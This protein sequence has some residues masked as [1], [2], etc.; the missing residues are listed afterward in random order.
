MKTIQQELNKVDNWNKRWRL[1][2]N[3]EQRGYVLEHAS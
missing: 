3:T 2:L 1:E